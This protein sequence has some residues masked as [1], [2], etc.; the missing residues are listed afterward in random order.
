ME[1][2]WLLS[3]FLFV[4]SVPFAD[5]KKITIHMHYKVMNYIDTLF[6]LFNNSMEN[7]YIEIL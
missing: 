5:K 2:F 1:T 7:W 4:L 6:I 3:L